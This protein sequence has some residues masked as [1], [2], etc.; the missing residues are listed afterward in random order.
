MHLFRSFRNLLTVAACLLL[1]GSPA[2]AAEEAKR[3]NVIFILA[4]DK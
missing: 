3:P 4:D 1:I 2:L